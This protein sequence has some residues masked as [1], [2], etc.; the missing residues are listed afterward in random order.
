MLTLQ[1]T[2]DNKQV[3]IHA[4]GQESHS[5]S[6]LDLEQ[7][8]KEWKDFFKDPR[9]YGGKLFQA[10]FKD[11]S[12]ARKA[13]D[14][15]SKQSE[16]TIV[17]VLE[18]SELDGTAWEYAYHDN[19]YIVEDF[20]FIRALPEK[21]RPHSHGRLRKSV[22]RLPLLFIPANPLV[23][24]NGEPMRELDIESEWREM[25]QHIIK[26]NA[27]FDLIELRPS[28]PSALQSVMAR[29]QNGMIA[30]F[31]GH[32]AATKD[33][34]FLLFENEN[35]SSNPLEAREFVREVK[36]QAWIGF[37]S[38]CQSAV[39]ERTEFGNLARELVKAGVPFALGMQFNLPDLFAPNI[40]GQFYNYLS[41]GHAVPEA[42]RQARRAVKRENEFYVGMIALYAAHPD[43]SGK[44]GWTGSGARTL[45]TFAEADVSDLPTPSGFIGRQRELMNIGTSLLGKKKP[46]TV[47]L[48]G[49]GGI[50]KTALMRQVL[51]RFAPSFE[52][53]L[54]IALDSL[55]SLESVLGRL[56]Q[57]LNLPLPCANDTKER[58]QIVRGKLTGRET[59]LGLDNFETLI[60]ARDNGSD[61]EK[62]TAKS[63]YAFF[64]RLAAEGVTLC[65]TSRE[66]TNLP[67]ETIQEIHGLEDE[68]GGRLF[69]NTVSTRRDA[70]TEEGLEKIS[71]AVGG[72][73]LALRLLAPIF[74]EQA[75]LTLDDFVQKL[76]TFLPK[77]SDQWT[78][79]ERHESLG[80]CF[81]F[82]MDN[83]PKNEEGKKLQVAISRLSVFTAFFFGF[84]AIPIV[85]NRVPE[86]EEEQKLAQVQTDSILHA[87]WERGL[88]ERATLAL[89]DENFYFYRLHPALRFFA[90]DR[91][92]DVE[93]VTENYWESM[94]NFARIVDEQRT[95]NPLTAQVAL[96]IVPDLLDAAESRNDKDSAVMQYRVGVL[97]KQFSLYD[98]ALRLLERCRDTNQTL[99]N[100]KGKSVALH[101]IA[102]IYFVHGDLDRAMKLHRESLKINEI[103]GDTKNK[104]KSLNN[105]ARIYIAHGDFGE[106]E[107]LYQQS[108]EIKKD[109]GDLSGIAATLN[110]WA[111]VHLTR[112][113]WKNALEMFQQSLE[114]FENLGDLRGKAVSQNGLASIYIEHG[115]LEKG[116]E[117]QN[118]SLNT[119]RMIGDKRGEIGA[120]AWIAKIREQKGDL[121]VAVMLYEEI[122]NIADQIGDIEGKSSSLYNIAQ[123][124][125]SQGDVNKALS[126]FNQLLEA[127]GGL[128]N[129]EFRANVLSS[130]A[131]NNALREDFDEAMK[132]YRQALQIQEKLG[133][134]RGK[135][136][137][138][139][140][141]AKVSV[142][143]GDL[144][145]AMQLYQEAVQILEELG[146]LRTKAV[147]LGMMS[148]VYWANQKYK[149]AIT[150]L[151]KGLMQLAELRIQP[152]TQQAM[153]SDMAYWRTELGK[154]KF[155]TLWKEITGN[156]IPEWLK[157]QPEEEGVTV[158]Q[159]IAGAIQS[160]REKR[161]EAEQ[162]FKEAQKIAIDSN[163]P[164]ELQVL[165]KVLQRIMIGEKNVDL[166][167]LTNELRE[168]VEKALE[169]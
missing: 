84:V 142:L 20:A 58:E 85:E 99:N 19:A 54:A 43:E 121:A 158:E 42:A 148:K 11:G 114:I 22:E 17:L 106:A 79:Q 40:S 132:L 44:M 133:D 83:L 150:L 75:G 109:L 103:L 53:A 63:L 55:P 140:G 13:F 5:F 137:T 153:A 56:E 4:K 129:L 45:S 80:V 98:D 33:G 32:G 51:L 162:Y 102:D 21:E 112:G 41:Q 155:D 3:T 119:F 60:H 48:H 46:N 107:K 145:Y 141:M 136:A 134:L 35:G 49:A 127:E 88:L 18:S 161:P 82:S 7:T 163:T 144:D 108:L 147:A 94:S 91:L 12:E 24:L 47:T 157:Q 154:Q 71:V 29:F 128:K 124:Y 1:L 93:T 81:A 100:Q 78:E 16:R 123:I 57:F 28:T 130:I 76:E 116:L 9:P 62:K 167:A 25:I 34:A 160:A 166:S 38:A 65:V 122:L 37:L 164:A 138:L 77:A 165:G 89:P 36:D 152:Q 73:P 111:K 169:G 101:E 135:S 139:F 68:V 39:A 6:L 70:L 92:T 10:L 104:S 74:E 69:Q 118:E 72:H 146:D 50:G 126:F 52:A 90:R 30:H 110:E 61:E 15:L 27:P 64:K 97:L 23:D 67:G 149:E 105:M 66:K 143:R 156:D 125:Q 120:L 31:S 14:D 26:S 95:K 87:L 113:D 115:N 8:D 159:F 117:L 96:R 86:S 151:L 168:I 131:D 2:L 59:L